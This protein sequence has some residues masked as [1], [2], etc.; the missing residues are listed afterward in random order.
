MYGVRESSNFI[1]YTGYSSVP[2]P[3][4]EKTVLSSID[5]L[6][7]LLKNQLILMVRVYFWTLSHTSLVY[8]FTVLTQY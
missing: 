1:F 4:A 2:T 5:F 8:R 3:F 6:G 7:S